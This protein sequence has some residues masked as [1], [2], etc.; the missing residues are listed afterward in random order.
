[1]MQ[2]SEADALLSSR[3][4]ADELSELWRNRCHL[5]VGNGG[6]ASQHVHYYVS[7][8]KVTIAADGDL[9]HTSRSPLPVVARGPHPPPTGS[10]SDQSP[11][12]TACTNMEMWLLTIVRS[13]S[14]SALKPPAPCL[15]TACRQ[16]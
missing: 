5:C 12:M 2:W 9:R 14:S 11:L 7:R 16:P 3:E 8:Y 13:F 10:I 6:A 4:P 15:F 1:M